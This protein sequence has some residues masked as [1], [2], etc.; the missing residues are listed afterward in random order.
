LEHWSLPKV[1]LHSQEFYISALVALLLH[2]DRTGPSIVHSDAFITQ[3]TTFAGGLAI[4]LDRSWTEANFKNETKIC[5]L[6]NRGKPLLVTIDGLQKS[7]GNG[8]S[9]SSSTNTITVADASE[10]ARVGW[11]FSCDLNQD[12]VVDMKDIVYVTIRFNTVPSSPNWDPKADVNNDGVVNFRDLQIVIY[13]FK[14]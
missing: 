1:N 7:E 4:S 13:N 14:K 5:D 12:G 10:S 3:T 8:W 11:T 2:Y 9:W 6:G